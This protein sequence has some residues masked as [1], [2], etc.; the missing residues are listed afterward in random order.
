[1]HSVFWQIPLHPNTKHKKGFVTH[2]GN[3]VFNKFTFGLINSPNAFAMVMSEV[4]HGINWRFAQ[5]YVDDIF[6]YS[7]DFE[8]HLKHLQE[9][10]DHFPKANLKLKPSKC[11]FAARSVRYLGH[12]FSS[13]GIFVD[14]E[15]IAS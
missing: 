4:L 11:C 9:I 14:E 8:Q 1:M 13:E 15:K 5:V 12:R 10:F 7:S 2:E 3:Y 6:V